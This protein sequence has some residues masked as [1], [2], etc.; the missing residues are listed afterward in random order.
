[1]K[2][3]PLA[4]PLLLVLVGYP[5]SGK[6]HFAREIS[7]R[8]VFAT[9]SGDRIRSEIFDQPAFGKQDEETVG[10]IASY[11]LE[12]LVKTKSH[13]IYDAD[14]MTKNSRMALAKIAR[15]H[16]YRMVTIWVQT[17]I[18]TAFFRS[19]KRSSSRVGDTYSTNI[20]RELFDRLC[21]QF[22]PPNGNE[23]YVVISGK[24]TYTT[25]LQTLLKRLQLLQDDASGTRKTV[26]VSSPRPTLPVYS[27][28]K[29]SASTDRNDTPKRSK[30]TISRRLKL[31]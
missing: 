19:S 21:R 26:A 22:T 16:G 13:I 10:R 15:D 18:E 9:V 1:M 31:R 3:L 5:G 23:P 11:Q 28:V 29:N 4:E 12:E 6:S 17:D 27:D 20:S 14:G 8:Y 24:H 25:Q 30:I 7:Q 2:Q